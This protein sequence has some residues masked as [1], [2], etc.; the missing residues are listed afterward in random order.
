MIFD[1][2]KELKDQIIIKPIPV[3]RWKEYRELRLEALKDEPQ[4]FSS[5]YSDA[6]NKDDEEWKRQL[7][8]YLEEKESIML[9]A[10]REG[11]TVGMLGVFWE[12]REKTRH[13]CN[14]FGFYVQKEYRNKGIGKSLIKEIIKKLRLKKQFEKVKLNVVSDNEGALVLYKKFGFEIVGKLEK[15]LKVRNNYYDEYIMELFI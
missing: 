9:F 12:E 14:L 15:E 6:F 5:S 4:A 2:M 10:E 11:E 8:N 1:K 7:Q 13:I 3:E